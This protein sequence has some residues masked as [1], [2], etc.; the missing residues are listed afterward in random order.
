MLEL[1]KQREKARGSG[2]GEPN[3]PT[4]KV[5]APAIDW[6]LP[7]TPPQRMQPAAVEA[8]VQV[9]ANTPAQAEAA[10]Q[11]FVPPAAVNA[12][13][14]SVKPVVKK[15]REPAQSRFGAAAAAASAVNQGTDAQTDIASKCSTAA[16]PAGVAQPSAGSADQVEG[17][18]IKAS[19]GVNEGSPA[20]PAEAAM[21]KAAEAEVAAKK[22]KE[23]DL[24]A[25]AKKK[26]DQ[27]LADSRRQAAKASAG[28]HLVDE[29]ADRA[30]ALNAKSGTEGEDGEE[31]VQL[32]A[33]EMG[34]PA[35]AGDAF[36]A[37]KAKME[38]QK[39]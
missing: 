2:L 35:E 32:S 26:K 36:A 28:S 24:Q 34:F 17:G 30:A 8:F 20:T 4:L 9:A 3:L 10:E 6:D 7:N 38:V 13:G 27:D 1:I 25:E 5:P 11:E 33:E 16:G 21:K 12:S 39:S 29:A 19:R 15:S 23:Q 18:A 22:K 31:D 37:L 14:Q